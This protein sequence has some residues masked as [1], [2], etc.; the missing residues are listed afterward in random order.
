MKRVSIEDKARLLAGASHWG[1]NALPELGVRHLVLSDGPHGLRKQEGAADH[2]GIAESVPATCFPSASAL[3]CSFDPKL[4]EE[5]GAALGEEAV[6]QGVDVVLG[7]GVNIKRHPLCGRNFEYFSEDPVVSGELGAAMVRGIQSRGVSACL[8]HFA[9][10]SQEHARMVSDSI[11]DER[12]LREVYLAPFEQVVRQARPHSIMTAY[13][14]LNGAYCS[15]NTWLLHDVLRGEWG[16]D[17]VVVS[18][19][20]AMSSSVDSVRAGLDLCMPG[21]RPDHASAIA[22]AV[23]S[24]ALNEEVVDERVE[25]LARWCSCI[26]PQT[27]PQPHTDRESF[28]RTHA[29]V[30]RRAAAQSAVLLKNTGVLPLETSQT[31]AVIGSF[32]RLPRYQGSGSSK[33][34]PKFLD[35]VWYRMEQRGFAA[36]YADGYEPQMGETSERML[37]EAERAAAACDVA[38]VVAG[39]PDRYE[40]EGFDRKRMVMPRGHV[41][42]IERVCAVNPR[43]VVVLQGGAPME[44]P[45]RDKPAAILLMYL[46]GC[47][48]GAAA[49]DIIAGDVNPSGKLAETWPARLEDTA[50]GST[51]PDV[52]REVRYRESVFVGYRY[53]DAAGIEPAYPFGH[54][55][56]YT[57]F[58]YRDLTVK[59]WTVS[60]T[61][62]NI[63]DRA[64]AEV[65]QLYAAP[66]SGVVPTPA[67][68]ARLVAFAKVCLEPGE[69]T[70]VRMALAPSSLRSWDVETHDWAVWPGDYEIR[71]SSSSRD[72]RLRAVL[73]VAPPHG[74]GPVRPPALSVPPIYAHPHPGCFAAP[75]ADDAFAALYGSDMPAPPPVRPFTVD[76]TVADMGASWFGRRMFRL[77]DWVLAKPVSNMDHV[78]KI[79]MKEMAAD[80]PLRSMVTSGVPLGAVEGF[81]SMLNGRYVSGLIRIVREFARLV[82]AR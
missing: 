45:W 9:G 55:L 44:M 79:M 41:E 62:R 63:G 46:S 11:I 21:A 47:Q 12:A 23:Q 24:G 49:V 34:R 68:P 5:V 28:Y 82:R 72:I 38:V 65:V 37:L 51:F 30:A 80:M 56:S 20:G 36:T 60:V 54:G 18:D 40:S 39:L 78:Q 67:P 64:G 6:D 69:E 48:G 50:L 73:H 57:R 71:A 29:A 32:A 27:L 42:L 58:A 15:Q 43:T 3:A 70:A 74:C 53:Y 14:R 4:I 1:T 17:G 33:T 16:F 10:N 66:A 13:N 2:L 75:G 81:V 59:D 76:S 35:N 26:R 19:W 7:P 8:K 52:D 31:V 22:R 25:N 61:V 77:I